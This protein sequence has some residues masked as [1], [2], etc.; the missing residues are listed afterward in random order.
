[1]TFLPLSTALWYNPTI[2]WTEKQRIFCL[3]SEHMQRWHTELGGNYQDN[4]ELTTKIQSS[5]CLS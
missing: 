3:R 1:M 4:I 5:N 2:R